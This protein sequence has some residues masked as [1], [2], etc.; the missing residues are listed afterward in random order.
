MT[1]PYNFMGELLY[2]HEASTYS[3]QQDHVPF[4]LCT[5]VTLKACPLIYFMHSP[6]S[7][8]ASTYS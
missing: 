1:I 5:Q 6:C 3:I 7:F 2:F 4:S 8:E